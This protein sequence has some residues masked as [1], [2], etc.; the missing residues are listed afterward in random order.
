MAK[1]NLSILD[2]KSLIERYS[3]DLRL[4]DFQ[5]DQV[6]SAIANLESRVGKTTEK[7]TPVEKA[8]IV[9]APK[10]EKKVAPVAV[11]GDAPK[12]KAG[13]P[14]KVVAPAIVEIIEDDP[15]LEGETII[16]HVSPPKGKKGKAAK[17]EK[18][19][20]VTAEVQVEQKKRGPKKKEAVE[21]AD[22]PQLKRGRVPSLSEWD[23]VLI[24]TLDEEHKLMKSG[25]LIESFKD[26]R[27]KNNIAEG[28]TRMLERLNQSLVKLN[29]MG[30][31]AKEDTDGR[32]YLYGLTE[33]MNKGAFPKKFK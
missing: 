1:D 21:K 31:L 13:R 20:K 19:S 10:K 28:D 17:A 24:S 14:P 16:E 30:L 33:W 32:G 22:K 26:Y 25:D 2:I 15:S 18:K 23:N 6:K 9:V 29:K 7:P 27:S 8:P 5:A 3:A 11:A 12:R 4:L